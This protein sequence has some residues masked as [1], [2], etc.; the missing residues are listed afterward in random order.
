MKRLS[1][2]IIS[3][4]A[5]LSIA[6]PS[7]AAADDGRGGNTGNVK[8]AV[9]NQT[10]C[11]KKGYFKVLCD[12]LDIGKLIVGLINLIFILSV[13]VALLYLIWGGFKWLTSGGDKTAVQGAREHLVAAI[14]GLVVI[15]LS[16]FILN[17]VVG[18]FIPGFHL[19][20]FVLPTLS[21]P[22]PGT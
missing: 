6:L 13:V 7:L 9:V 8:N 11:A 5:F 2:F 20:E 1:S 17:F 3:A 4:F 12:N 15:F 19:N 21:N 18:F 14:V 16:Y 10:L 22:S